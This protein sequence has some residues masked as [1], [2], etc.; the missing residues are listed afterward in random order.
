MVDIFKKE[1]CNYCKN[2]ECQEN[3]YYK[4]KIIDVKIDKIHK[5]AC[6]DYTKDLSKIKPIKPPLRVT[7]ERDYIKYYER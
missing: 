2:T 4:H 3:E 6:S 1:I 7:A 5:Y